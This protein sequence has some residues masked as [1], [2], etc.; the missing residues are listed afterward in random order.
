MSWLNAEDQASL[1]RWV[2]ESYQDRH[3]EILKEVLD[4]TRN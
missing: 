3:P 1:L 2:C 4:H